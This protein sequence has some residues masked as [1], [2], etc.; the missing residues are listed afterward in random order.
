MAKT[1]SPT[2]QI[3]QYYATL[4]EFAQQN[5]LHE[6]A[7][8]IAF[9]TLL[10][11][12]ARSHHW[13]LIPQLSD[14]TAGKSIRPDGTLKDP[15]G[16]VRGHWEAKDTADDLDTEIAKKIAKNYPLGNII[17]EDT[18]RAVLM[19][20][21]DEVMR[22]DMHNR[23]QLAR[24]LETFFAYVEPQIDSFEKAVD[25]FKERV[26]DIALHLKAKIVD[27]HANNK[28]FKEA[29]AKFLELCQPN[30]EDD[31]QYI[32][33]LV[34]QVVR[35]SVETV[36]IVKGLPEAFAQGLAK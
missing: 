2:A 26:P 3:D 31:E 19:Q 35:V 5:A 22:V 10:A 23:E 33:R 24:L 25:E 27:A 20:N 18:R 12:T 11:D 7:V 36:G 6:G 28:K 34:G 8:S 29:F 15:M 1:K 4:A 30:R 9:Q 21:K 17:F 16:L 13:T 32:V 14:K